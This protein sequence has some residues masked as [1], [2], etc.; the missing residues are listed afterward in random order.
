[1]EVKSL[2]VKIGAS[3]AEMES[4]F[5]KA[6][7]YL[8]KHEEQFKKVGRGVTIAGAAITGA[9]GSILKTAADAQET[10]SKFG[11]VFRN[12]SKEAGTSARNLARDYGLSEVASK[13][14]LAATGD[15][16]TGLGVEADVALDLSN[17]TQQ[18]AVDLASFTNYSG[19][20]KGASDALTKAMLGEREALKSLGIVVTQEMVD[21]QLL[22]E[23]KEHL[24][25][26]AKKQA[27]AEATLA[28]AYSQSENA[29]G[30]YSRTSGD[31]TNVSRQLMSQITDIAVEIGTQLIP[32]ATAIALKIKEVLGGV[33][34]WVKENPKLTKTLA[35]VAAVLGGLMI[36]IGP[37]IMALPALSAGFVALW[38]AI[39]G[40]VGLVIAAIAAVAAAAYLIYD[41]WEPIS[42]F[43]SKLWGSVSGW[44]VTAFENIKKK[45]LDW[46]ITI[47]GILE[48]IPFVKKLAGPWK[49][50]LQ[51]MR[52]EMDKTTEHISLRVGEVTEEGL[53]M[54]GA[55]VTWVGNM[56]GVR[57]A[58]NTL[59]SALLSMGDNAE[60]SGEDIDGVKT[61][62]KQTTELINTKLYPALGKLSPMLANVVA[63]WGAQTEIM[64][65]EIINLSLVFPEELEPSAVDVFE[66][67][68]GAG[69]V[70]STRLAKVAKDIKMSFAD[71]FWNILGYANTVISGMDAIFQQSFQNQMIRIDNEEKRTYDALDNK[72]DAHIAAANDLL[73]LEQETTAAR[74]E[75]LDAWYEKQKKAIEDSEMD[76][77][78]K[79][80]ALKKLDNKLAR[81]RKRLIEEREVAEKEAADNLEQLEYAKNEA[82]RVAAIDLENQRQA[83][84]RKAAKQEKAVALLSAIVNTAAAVAKAL[85]NIP[86]AIAVG[87][88]GAIQIGLIAS[89]PL[90]ALAQGGVVTRPTKALIGEAGPE[91][92]IPLSKLNMQPAL[93]GIG[94]IQIRQ[95]NYFY[96]DINEAGDL[97]EISRQL[98]EKTRRAL[99]R[100]QV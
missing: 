24:T 46:S 11:T 92:I 72:Y 8:K 17:R 90:P 97:D 41:N 33:L 50:T 23:G 19:G 76:E 30:D 79:F 2:L 18:L 63:N 22:A 100:G 80:K 7:T 95:N 69:T 81:K 1:M 5:N 3:V 70:L 34:A 99:E 52:D 55:F 93:A 68:A 4:Q 84:R 54:A 96:G 66:V 9:V 56:K 58:A 57:E 49:E 67:L 71:A 26:M 39:T 21:E 85:P 82:L 43:F 14:L 27:E 87:I 42:E 61:K 74:F 32:V 13:G 29:V 98:A 28:I 12:V 83:A 44:F 10:Y 15:L 64:E 38:T 16:L 78:A 94:G 45:L 35:M 20:A 65:E 62:L 73:T 40:P 25:G 77:E 48:K 53:E 86:L 75:E 31:L 51:S 47:A 91:A 37:L 89:Q 60:E 36:V 88:M 6:D 59:G